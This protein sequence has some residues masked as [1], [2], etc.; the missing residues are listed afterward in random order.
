MWEAEFP[1]FFISMVTFWS[2][3]SKTR[4]PIRLKIKSSLSYI[5]KYIH[6]NFQVSRHNSFDD[7]VELAIKIIYVGGGIYRFFHIDGKFLEL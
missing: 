5:V 7:I 6:I 1:V 2:Y 4:S 3:K